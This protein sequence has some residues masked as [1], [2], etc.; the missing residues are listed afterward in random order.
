M[1]LEAT[2]SDL[3]PE[4]RRERRK[5]TDESALAFARTYF[6]QVFTEPWSDLHRHMA[7]L[8]EGRYSI[9]GFPQSGKSAFAML[10]VLVRHIAR[11]GGEVRDGGVACV[12]ARTEDKAKAHT[13][14]IRRIIERAEM[15]RYD[16]GIE[17]LQDKAGDH[18]FKAEDGQTRLVAASVNK[19]VRGTVD[20]DFNRITLAIG[21]DLY[22]RETA[23]S[24]YD[25]ERVYK[26]IT[27]ELY[28][29]LEDDALAIVLGNAI[30]EGCP[31]LKLKE[32]FP[33]RHYSFPIMED[34]EPT[35]PEVY[36]R[37][38]IEEKKEET[39][40]DVW[41]GEY[42]ERP[43][44]KGDVF[45]EEWLRSVSVALTK[46]V[47]SLT[48]ID[49]ARGQSPQACRKGCFTIGR[50]QNGTHVGLDVWL[51]KEAYEHLFDHVVQVLRWAPN[52]KAVLFENDFAQFDYAK[53]YYEQWEEDRGLTLPLIMHRASDLAESGRSADKESRIMNLVY[54]HD[55]GAFVYLD[56]MT[57]GED[58]DRY[59]KEVLAFG[60]QKEGL[61][62]LDAAATAYIMID[63][64]QDR[65][66]FESTADRQIQRPAWAGS[67]H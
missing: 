16:F 6:P 24:D 51:R 9:S 35:W 23:S 18:L 67:F 8:E 47:A 43:A 61:D 38:D 45:E 4:K 66:T 27:G 20:M 14:M 12:A 44:R 17:V 54:P 30:V 2:E 65:G 39:D 49:P 60:Q 34:G 42:M 64:Y 19:G 3:T 46:I 58:W 37:E 33:N 59:R 62:G 7:S 5:Q 36:S 31:I 26:W 11:A 63:R 10:G 52:H 57:D 32:E 56:A 55:T 22:D 28:R 41:E 13:R 48:A 21:D 1:G 15:L 40:F 25:N 50:T 53:P 29:Q